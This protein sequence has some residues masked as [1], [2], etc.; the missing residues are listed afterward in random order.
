MFCCSAV[1]SFLK[2]LHIKTFSSFYREIDSKTSEIQR[3]AG[4][5]SMSS[6]LSSPQLNRLPRMGG[7]HDFGCK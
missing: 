6:D 4:E 5:L 1:T 7:F 3:K 2:T